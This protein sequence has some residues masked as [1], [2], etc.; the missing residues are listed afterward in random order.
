MEILVRV[1]HNYGNRVIYPVCETARNFP[2]IAG[3]K[4]LKLETVNLIKKLG[5]KVNVE[6]EVV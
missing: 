1:A 6:N 5:Y 4:T 3:T 2:E